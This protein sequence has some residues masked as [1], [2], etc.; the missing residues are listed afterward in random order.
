MLICV[1]YKLC[2]SDDVIKQKIIIIFQSLKALE[3]RCEWSGW[4]VHYCSECASK[5]V[6]LYSH[7]LS[8]TYCKM[9]Q[10]SLAEETLASHFS[11][12]Y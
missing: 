2:K 5:G 3:M 11:Y 7:F 12:E 8:L 4:S 6:V 10:Y 1:C 9:T